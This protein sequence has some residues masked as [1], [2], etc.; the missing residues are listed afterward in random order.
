MSQ[1]RNENEQEHPRQYRGFGGDWLDIWFTLFVIVAVL[2]ALGYYISGLP[3]ELYPSLLLIGTL[4]GLLGWGFGVFL[5]PYSKS[6]DSVIFSPGN[7]RLLTGLII[8]FLAAWFWQ[9]IKQF[10][11]SCGPD[12]GNFLH[13]GLMPVTAVGLIMFLL[14]T[15]TT[16][17][18]RGFNRARS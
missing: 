7:G 16:Y 3:K 2:A 1:T 12:V 4:G 18:M 9:P 13:S 10:L 6:G 15:I 17:I 8:G 14:A 11:T 5:S